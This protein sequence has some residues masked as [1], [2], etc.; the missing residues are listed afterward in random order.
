MFVFT[1]KSRIKSPKKTFALIICGIIVIG[2]V[3]YIWSSNS[4]SVAYCKAVGEYSTRFTTERDKKDFLSLFN[5][6][7]DLVDIDYVH[8]PTSFNKVYEKYNA[9][10]RQMGLDLQEYRGK[11]AKRYVYETKDKYYVSVLCY[12]NRVIACHKCTN[13]YGEDFK[14]LI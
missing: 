6:S 10:Q 3:A 5:V 9:V 11:T 7:G 8:I 12:Q 1:V 13:I 4:S 2:V 14:A